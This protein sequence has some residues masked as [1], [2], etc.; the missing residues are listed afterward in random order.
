[1]RAMATLATIQK[2]PV[3]HGYLI[4]HKT[5][6]VSQEVV[7]QSRSVNVHDGLGI[8]GETN[9]WRVQRR[10]P[11]TI[12]HNHPSGNAS[13][14]SPSDYVTGLPVVA[15]DRRGN[16]YRGKSKLVIEDDRYAAKDFQD[17]IA[18]GIHAQAKEEL[19]SRVPGKRLPSRSHHFLT[20]HHANKQMAKAGVQ[21]YRAKLNSS[22]QTAERIAGG[23]YAK[24]ADKVYR[25]EYFTLPTKSRLREK[26]A[27][28]P[29]RKTILSAK[30]IAQQS[31]PWEE[32]HPL[33]HL[34][35]RKQIA[36]LGTP[37][38]D[39]ASKMKRAAGVK[40]KNLPA[41]LPPVSQD[42][43]IAAARQATRGNKVVARRM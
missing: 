9:Q 2:K 22:A 20:Y 38:Q 27:T 32:R 13:P 7:G 34:Q 24:A 15:I 4:N 35:Q 26:L 11:A 31:R 33:K 30:A 18:K 1:M 3:E 19:S 42:I 6:K 17:R 39:W 5:G 23:A 28:P 25:K 37:P 41:I 12:L 21:T 40:V 14:L 16:T 29:A 36:A 8:Q 43:A 10:K